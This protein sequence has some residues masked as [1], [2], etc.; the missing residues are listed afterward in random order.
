[1]SSSALTSIAPYTGLDD[2]IQ[3]LQD[4]DKTNYGFFLL[5]YNVN[6]NQQMN[7]GLNALKDT[8]QPANLLKMVKSPKKLGLLLTMI[9]LMFVIITILILV[10]F[11]IY[12]SA[13]GNSFKKELLLYSSPIVVGIILI[14]L[15]LTMFKGSINKEMVKAYVMLPK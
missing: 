1:M 15:L 13:R 11:Y 4:G 8:Q 10:C 2:E 3:Q 7:Q 9:V 6:G 14:I 5:K 12:Y